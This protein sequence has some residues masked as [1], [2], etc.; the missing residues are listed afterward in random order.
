MKCVFAIVTIAAL[1]ATPALA[2]TD[3]KAIAAF[4][5]LLLTQAA[6]T[7]RAA[8]SDSA[9]KAYAEESMHVYRHRDE[10]LKDDCQEK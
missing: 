9:N 7:A 3:W 5:T 6:E 10:A 4:D 8:Q 2:S 1:A